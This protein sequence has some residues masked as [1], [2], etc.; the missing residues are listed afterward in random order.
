MHAQV[1]ELGL[2]GYPELSIC[3]SGLSSENTVVEEY[4]RR[5]PEMYT[6]TYLNPEVCTLMGRDSSDRISN[7]LKVLILIKRTFK[8][9]N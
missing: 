1:A 9:C 4:L 2:G 7:H 3:K 8:K 6:C 5:W